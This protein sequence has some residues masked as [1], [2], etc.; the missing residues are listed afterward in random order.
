MRPERV[1]VAMVVACVCVCGE[2]GINKRWPWRGGGRARARRVIEAGEAPWSQQA[3][4]DPP[5]ALW[6]RARPHTNLRWCELH[7]LSGAGPHVIGRRRSLARAQVHVERLKEPQAADAQRDGGDAHAAQDL[8]GAVRK[9]RGWMGPAGCTQPMKYVGTMQKGAETH[10]TPNCMR[11]PPGF[12]CNGLGRRCRGSHRS[13]V[14]LQG[15][16]GA[17]VQLVEQQGSLVDV[18]LLPGQVGLLLNG[19]AAEGSPYADG[20]RGEGRDRG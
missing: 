3:D 14:L 16:V 13:E 20:R 19:R 6:D 18:H 11:Q 2:G 10:I 12:D 9:E 4:T 15:R 1:A 5:F 17:L 7:T 8:G